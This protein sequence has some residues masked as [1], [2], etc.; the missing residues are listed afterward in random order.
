MTNRDSAPF[1]YFAAPKR[2]WGRLQSRVLFALIDGRGQARTRE[3]A[4]VCWEAPPTP[5]QIYSQGRACKAIGAVR[6]RREG[7]EM[8]RRSVSVLPATAQRLRL[9][10]A[11]S[12]RPLLSAKDRSYSKSELRFEV[13]GCSQNL[14]RCTKCHRLYQ[15]P[16]IRTRGPIGAV[17]WT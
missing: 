12:P 14:R 2:R 3:I 4:S 1:V 11:F 10:K 17:R 6:V 7:Q 9:R 13:D 8:R 15:I 16:L 5:R